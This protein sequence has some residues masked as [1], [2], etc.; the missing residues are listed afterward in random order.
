MT[1]R[2]FHPDTLA[3]GQTVALSDTA[4]FHASKVLRLT[5]A[6]AIVLFNGDAHP[7]EC[8]LHRDG[9]LVLATVLAKGAS[10][11]KPAFN[12]VLAQALL[13]NEKMAWV[14]EK[15]VELGVDQ[16]VPL[17]SQSAKVKLDPERGQAKQERWQ[18]IAISACAQ[19][20]RNTLVQI[21]SPISFKEFLHSASTHPTV[22]LEPG[23]EMSLAQR[24]TQ[25]R[26]AAGTTLQI[27]IGPESGFSFEEVEQAK[28]AGAQ[29][30][31]LGWRVLRTET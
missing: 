12:R 31:S 21:A 5:D 27:M 9:K 23:S 17:S 4:S 22:L 13:S 14:I 11:P 3:V 10:D 20:G 29:V 30:A 8:Q 2:F 24:L 26:P 1:P 18:D 15:A 25:Q 6:S 19:C 28:K 16:I 7:Y